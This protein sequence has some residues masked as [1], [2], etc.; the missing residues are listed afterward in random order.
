MNKI[1]LI[2]LLCTA[3]FANAGPYTDEAEKTTSCEIL[4]ELASSS[5]AAKKVGVTLSDAKA[6]VAN[7]GEHT[8]KLI[9]VVEAG[10]NSRSEKVA[11]R[12]TFAECMDSKSKTASN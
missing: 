6:Q 10:Y 7:F 1:L 4:G 2:A 9:K 3:Q 11:Y 5:F 12:M 8:K